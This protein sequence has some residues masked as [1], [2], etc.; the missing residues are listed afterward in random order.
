MVLQYAGHHHWLDFRCCHLCEMIAPV[1]IAQVAPLYLTIPPKKYGAV[2][3][4]IFYLTEE[5]CRNG[6]EV[7]LFASG[8]SRTS[9]RLIAPWPTPLRAAQMSPDD[10]Q[11]RNTLLLETVFQ[12]SA[13]FDI[14]HFHIDCLHF[15]LSRLHRAAN[16]TTLHRPLDDPAH[17][18]LFR[19]FNEMPLI[20]ISDAQRAA[21]PWL[22]WKA[23]I[24]NGLPEDL[25]TFQEQP[26]KYLAFLGRLCPEKGLD[27]AIEIATKSGLEL[28]VA[29]MVTNPEYFQKTMQPVINHP[30]IDFIG[31][32]GEA[33]KNDFLG[34]AYA[35]LFPIGW[36][37]PLGLVMLEAM[38][39]GTPIIA[40]RH[41]AVPE[42]VEDGVNGFIVETVEEA[43]AAI[44]KIP[45]LS[46]RRCRQVFE[47][48]FT[49]ARMCS[50]HLNVFEALLKEWPS[51]KAV[52]SSVSS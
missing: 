32:I 42:V 11:V 12:H 45:G 7:T 21:T 47:E 10:L 26:G 3:R 34:S 16:I 50:N 1:K 43:V 40:F 28:K 52:A 23:T 49:V 41:G 2:E 18:P 44:A 27:K 33:T 36:N 46:R 48:R 39:C 25:Y 13:K 24:Y 14:I 15:P 17:F 31:E 5:L 8:D 29:G 4:D 35:F 20:S 37:E 38:A 19:E 51:R 22:N 9:A 6:H 30:G